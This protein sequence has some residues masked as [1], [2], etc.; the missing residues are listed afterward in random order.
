MIVFVMALQEI[1]SDLGTRI[2]ELRNQRGW[3]QKELARRAGMR[4]ARLSTVES[5]SKRPNLDEFVR[6]ADALEVSLDA[7][8]SGEEAARAALRGIVEA[9]DAIRGRLVELHARL[10][11]PPEETAMLTGAMEMDFPTEVRSVIECVLNDSLQPAIR[12]LAVAATYQA[13]KKAGA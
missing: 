9:L 10:P 7:L 13:R 4:A 8:R 5:A 11:L 1:F 12:D 2:V 6:L 3:T